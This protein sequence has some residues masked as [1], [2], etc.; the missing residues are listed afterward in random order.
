M[1]T[2]QEEYDSLQI[3]NLEVMLESTSSQLEGGR[4]ADRRG[5]EGL[6]VETS[7]EIRSMLHI[8]IL[9]SDALSC[10]HN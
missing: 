9:S 10:D 2:I 4:G 3:E 6:F 1:R 7:Y 5:W 8:I